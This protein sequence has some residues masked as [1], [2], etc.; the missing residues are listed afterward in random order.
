MHLEYDFK[1][2]ENLFRSEKNIVIKNQKFNFKKIIFT[3]GKNYNQISDI[4]KFSFKSK[5]HAYV[6]FFN[7]TKIHNNIAYEYF[8]KIGPLAVLPAPNKN[9]NLSTFILS[10]SK[11][12]NEIELKKILIK[13]FQF[14]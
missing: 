14:S 1:M 7:H 12:F 13:N 9:K 4:K 10:S 6:G 8:T 11:K 3:L 5:H 2:I